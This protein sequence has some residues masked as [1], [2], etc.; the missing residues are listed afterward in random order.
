MYFIGATAKSRLSVVIVGMT[1]RDKLITFSI[2]PSPTAKP[3]ATP[4]INKIAEIS[5]KR[6]NSV[7]IPK[8]FSPVVVI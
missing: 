5:P 4:T 8:I 3:P 7:F 1:T 6:W 2:A